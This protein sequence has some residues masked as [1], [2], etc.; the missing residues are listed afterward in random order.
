LGEKEK[1]QAIEDFKRAWVDQAHQRSHGQTMIDMGATGRTRYEAEKEMRGND[2]RERELE[3]KTRFLDRRAYERRK[4]P[5]LTFSAP[6][7]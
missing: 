1:K 4:R 7:Q 6:S 5:L 2:K 3:D